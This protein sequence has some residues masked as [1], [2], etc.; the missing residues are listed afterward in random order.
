MKHLYNLKGVENMAGKITRQEL[1]SG[2]IT[3]LDNNVAHLDQDMPHLFEDTA[4]QKT[5]KYGFKQQDNHL[6]FMYQ[7]VV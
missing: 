2:L 1:S 3:E 4:A 5:Y 7:E 6:V